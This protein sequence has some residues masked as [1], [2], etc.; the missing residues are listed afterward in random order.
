MREGRKASRDGAHALP[1]THLRI[2]FGGGLLQ[3]KF[4]IQLK[5]SKPSPGI[6]Q[7][8]NQKEIQLASKGDMHKVR[9]KSN[10]L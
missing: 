10:S 5:K 9:T 6:N 8:T 2:S 1:T 4:K 3:T 7:H